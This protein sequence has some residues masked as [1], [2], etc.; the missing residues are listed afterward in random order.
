MDLSTTFFAFI[1][2]SLFLAAVG[3][4]AGMIALERPS[5]GP[6]EARPQQPSRS[7]HQP[8]RRRNRGRPPRAPPKPATDRDRRLASPA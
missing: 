8:C 7:Q 4:I 3:L 1:L 2:A 6:A 5:A